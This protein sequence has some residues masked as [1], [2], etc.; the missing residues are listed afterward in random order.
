MSQTKAQLIDPV[1]GSIVTADLADDAV[2]A[3]KLAS[4][5]V[6]NASVASNAAIDKSK[7]TEI[8]NG[9]LNNRVLTATGG[10]N[11]IQ[12]ESALS[13]NGSNLALG[14]SLELSSTIDTLPSNGGLIRHSNGYVY[15][16]GKSDGNGA[17]LSNGDGTATVRAL[18]PGGS[19]GA[20]N[21]ETGNGSSR[22]SIN[23][24]GHVVPAAD[25]TYDLGLTGTRFRAAY[26]DNYYG[27]GSNLTGISS[28]LV[29]DTSP[30]LGGNL[31][32]N[33]KNIN[34]GD[35][36]GSSDDRLNFGASTDMSIYHNGTNNIINSAGSGQMLMLQSNNEVRATGTVVRIMDENNSETMA[37][38]T[39]DGSVQLNHNNITSIE[40][41]NTGDA[42]DSNNTEGSGVKTVGNT[43]GGTRSNHG[44][45]CY[46]GSNLVALLA[47]HG[48]GPEGKLHLFNQGT[49]NLSM[50]G[51][52]GTMTLHNASSFIQFGSTSSAAHRLTDY[53]QGTYTPNVQTNN[54]VNAGLSTAFG[55]YVKIGTLVTVHIG[56]TTN[57]HSGVNTGQQYRVYLPFTA[58]NQAGVGVEGN[59][60][61]SQ[62]SIGS[63]NI[64]WMGG[65]VSNN[66]NFIYMHYHNGNNN[67]TNQL[68]P[69]AAN[70]QLHFRGTVVYRAA[71]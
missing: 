35:S 52:N 46:Q 18:T 60:I 50:N 4:N 43:G 70:N 54:G 64:S 67:N 56:I 61:C 2:D 29:N 22:L 32:V 16:G 66:F 12:G 26:V 58:A 51:T 11:S 57:S 31:D 9:N 17:I 63:Q 28:D 48:S 27:N 53:E 15:L 71:S 23:S 6:V 20:I 1:D 14:G 10:T 25:S 36:S 37:K 7:I 59:L 44:Y 55:S 21:F 68:T 8:V 19:N 13:F 42:G 45:Y 49:L 47:N 62:W 24:S 33:T 39:A 34:F 41:F 69:S 30:Q 5:A 65:E 38:F 3:S 40:T